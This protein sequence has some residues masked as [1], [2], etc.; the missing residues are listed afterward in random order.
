[1]KIN[2]FLG[3]EQLLKLQKTAFLC[4]RSITASAVLKCYDW[5]IAQREAGNCVI[6]G[7]HSQLEKDVLHYLLKGK[8]PIIIALARGL[9]KKIEPELIKPLE[10]GRIL[11]ISP[12]DKTVKRAS[13]QTAEIRNKMMIELADNITIGYASKEGKLEK[14]LQSTEKEIIRLV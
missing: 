3:N 7:F 5:A 13:E 8:Q 6:S 2:E 1:M 4:S 12:F 11:I 14:L 9:K 10:Q